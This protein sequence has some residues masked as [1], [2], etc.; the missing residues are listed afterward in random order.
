MKNSV[1]LQVG[2]ILINSGGYSRSGGGKEVPV[3][4]K[5]EILNLNDDSI[6]GKILGNFNH[7]GGD[8]LIIPEDHFTYWHV[9][10][11]S[12]PKVP[13]I[14]KNVVR[15]I[16][17]KTTER[18]YIEVVNNTCIDRWYNRYC[19]LRGLDRE[20]KEEKLLRDTII[21]D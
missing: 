10:K 18:I 3:V 19:D 11:T 1:N 16:E 15:T 6:V 20:V 5:V 8:G 21:E 4:F 2:D 17:T 13:A 9:F 12:A 14:V 7:H